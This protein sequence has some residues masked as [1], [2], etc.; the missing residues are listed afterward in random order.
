MKFG[1][2]KQK[3]Y[4]SIQICYDKKI[5]DVLLIKECV[6]WELTDEQNFAS[7]SETITLIQGKVA[8]DAILKKCLG[9]LQE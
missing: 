1:Q 6:S 8:F 7:R 5:S 9:E 2:R 3:C 4:L